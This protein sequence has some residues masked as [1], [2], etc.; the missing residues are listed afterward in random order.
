M[1]LYEEIGNEAV[2][3][4]NK[5]RENPTEKFNKSSTGDI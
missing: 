1:Y 3:L 2:N 5:L 4:V